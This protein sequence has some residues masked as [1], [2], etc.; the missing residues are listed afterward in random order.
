M[1]PTMRDVAE[2][3]GVSVAT[4]SRSLAGSAGVV[5]EVRERVRR[6]ADELGYHP[7]RLPSNLRAKGV[8]ILA[9]V[10]GNVRNT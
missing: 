2:R 8:R 4:V 3:A 9:L 1:G 6:V 10:V 5:P 7:S